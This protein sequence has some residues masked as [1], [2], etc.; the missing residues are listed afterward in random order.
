MRCNIIAEPNLEPYYTYKGR[1]SDVMGIKAPFS[2]SARV[3]IKE[4][5]FYI[6]SAILDITTLIKNKMKIFLPLCK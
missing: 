1:W 6:C 2:F 3:K 4:P 5:V